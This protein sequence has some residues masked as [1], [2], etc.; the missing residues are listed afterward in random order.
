MLKLFTEIHPEYDKI[1]K[2]IYRT[3]V[4][5]PNKLEG[6]E[7]IEKKKGSQSEYGHRTCYAERCNFMFQKEGPF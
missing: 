5:L 3:G 1:D 7:E 2:F 4:I 6:E